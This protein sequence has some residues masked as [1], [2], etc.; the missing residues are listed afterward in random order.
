MNP[1]G[2]PCPY[3]RAAPI[4]STTLQHHSVGTHSSG[5]GHI[6]TVNISM[7]PRSSICIPECQAGRPSPESKPL[8]I[9]QASCLCSSPSRA[10]T[11]Q[12]DHMEEGQENYSIHVRKEAAAEH[13]HWYLPLIQLLAKAEA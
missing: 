9:T 7:T 1:R 11:R 2:H 8:S 4:A 3:P 13:N 10:G 6:G 12:K 5:E